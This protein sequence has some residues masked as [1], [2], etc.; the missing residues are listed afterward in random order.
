MALNRREAE[1]RK[2]LF[3]A[4]QIRA[5]W[6]DVHQWNF[7][8]YTPIFGFAF[9]KQDQSI[10][11]DG[12]ETSLWFGLIPRIPMDEYRMIYRFNWKREFSF[13]PCQELA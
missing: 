3:I 7:C 5:S 8:V 12:L 11:K 13:V 6:I 1:R 10:N 9:R 4:L 2:S